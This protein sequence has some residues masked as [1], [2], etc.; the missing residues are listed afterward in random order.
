MSRIL[1]VSLFTLLLGGSSSTLGAATPPPP[2]QPVP[3]CHATVNGKC[4]VNGSFQLSSSSPGAHHY[5]VCR[6]EDTLAWG[7][8]N[9]VM[10]TN[11]GTAYTVSG[12]HLPSD[13]KRRAYYWSACDVANNCTLW[14]ANTPSYV[15]TDSSPPSAPGPTTTHCAYNATGPATCWVTGAF[16]AT[17]TP[18]TDSGSGVA[19]Y[20]ICRSQDDLAGFAGC[21]VTLTQSGGTT[22]TFA[23]TD[24]PSDGYQMAYH[25]RAKDALGTWGPW[26]DELYLRV[27]RHP[28]TV[29][30]DNASATTFPSR[31]ANVSA[32]DATAGA[33]ANSGL[34][35]VRYRW[36][37]ALDAGCTQGTATADG[38][39]LEVPTG[40]NWLYLCAR[41]RTGRVTSWDGG[42]YRVDPAAP[43]EITAD[44]GDA[45]GF[46]PAYHQEVGYSNGTY[47][48]LVQVAGKRT[49]CTTNHD[50][51][52]VL[53][54]SSVFGPWSPRG[55]SFSSARVT[56]CNT[57]PVF[58]MTTWGIGSLWQRGSTWYL[59]L[60]A[61]HGG[62]PEKHF[63]YLVTSPDGIAWQ[64]VTLDRRIIDGS[65]LEQLILYTTV[66]PTDESRVGFFYWTGTGSSPN[67][68]GYGQIELEPDERGAA[69]G[70]AVYLLD[71]A[72]NY[73]L[74]PEDG[75]V[76]FDVL[77][78]WNS[79][80]PRPGD[81]LLTSGLNGT[82]F[83]HRVRIRPGLYGCPT[84]ASNNLVTELQTST[85]TLTGLADPKLVLCNGKLCDRSPVP[86]AEGPAHNPRNGSP[87]IIQPDVFRDLDGRRYL[88][89]SVNTECDE[90][91]ANFTF[92]WLRPRLY[93]LND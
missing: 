54:S 22:Y 43:L 11:T 71:S 64:P 9:V 65:P 69:N 30:A 10:T 72:G 8:C 81:A 46:H 73:R 19:G 61:G 90:D 31:Q 26:N 74:L 91:P 87:G 75:D 67:N 18:A 35:A 55:G 79:G 29:S 50:Q 85:F 7:G 89:A 4:Y 86:I 41:D 76:D 62:D 52:I 32:A 92:W 44:H 5:R 45:L 40:D 66:I 39:A 63:V 24:L 15:Y 48:M 88:F 17:V 70:V 84:P 2:G 36:N 83:S 21:A 13:G 28:P 16:T 49:G 1:L 27:D 51:V 37:T 58:G 78:L 42:P 59:T 25:F 57:D 38:D 3:A 60:D 34:A 53:T 80:N 12:I 47:F 68:V 93:E 23:G 56:P 14:S 82:L 77:H 20:W 33:V 6:S